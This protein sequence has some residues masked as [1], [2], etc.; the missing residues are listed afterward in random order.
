VLPMLEEATM[1]LRHAAP[2]KDLAT[3]LA[4]TGSVYFF[5]AEHDQS[6]RL[7]EQALV[8]RQVLG[9]R[10]GV[11]ASAVNL[12]ELL[13]L[14]GDAEAA[15]AYAA[16]AETEARHRNSQSTLALILSNMAGY[17]LF[18]GDAELGGVAAYEALS[19]SRA[20]GQEYLCVM[21]LEH[22]ALAM[23][24]KGETDRA[25]C[26]LGF[27]DAH[28]AATG[29]TRERLEQA[30]HD[31]LVKILSEGFPAPAFAALREEGAAWTLE[32]AEAT[33]RLKPRP[34]AAAFV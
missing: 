22:L 15:L 3:A 5:N 27:A 2:H 28:Y 18:G 9:D 30:C 13:F 11:I 14:D 31:R 32:Q 24:L 17:R 23:A 29:Q 10:S 33:A 21:C 6:R 4:H 19:L 1:L 26:L 7:N 25:A 16:Q 8:M 34:L 12:A 20:I